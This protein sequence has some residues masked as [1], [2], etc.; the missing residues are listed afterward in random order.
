MKLLILS[1]PY[2]GATNFAE[3]LAKDLDHAFYQNPLDNEVPK[4]VNRDGERYW[5]PRGYNGLNSSWFDEYIYPND[6]PNNTIITHFVKWHKLP[7]NLYEE[8][9]LNAFIPK[10]DSVLIIRTDNWEDC[11]K[12][13][14]AAVAQPHENNFWWK[15]WLLEND[16]YDYSEDMFDLKIYDKYLRAH[17]W[18]KEYSQN[19]SHASVTTEELYGKYEH[20]ELHELMNSWNINGMMGFSLDSNNEPLKSHTW[21]NVLNAHNHQFKM[22]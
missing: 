21:V 10:F 11:W 2:C 8:Q 12:H 9:F 1:H 17:N 15:K 13:H 18:L 20:T 16:V 14:C 19:H 6:V 3:N 7:G 22:W 4:Y 5:V